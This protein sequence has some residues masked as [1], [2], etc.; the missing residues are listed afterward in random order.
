LYAS[1]SPAIG[2][3]ILSMTLIYF[4]IDL[5][6]IKKGEAYAILYGFYIIVFLWIVLIIINIFMF[7]FKSELSV[8]HPPD[9]PVN[10]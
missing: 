6:T 1:F 9:Q 7:K 5:A 10:N 4:F 8:R 2:N 3:T